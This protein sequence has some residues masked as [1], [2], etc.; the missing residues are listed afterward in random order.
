MQWNEA[1]VLEYLRDNKPLRNEIYRKL[2]RELVH[3][4][5]HRPDIVKSWKYYQEFLRICEV[6]D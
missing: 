6:L 4:K 1:R 3:I 5:S 2:E